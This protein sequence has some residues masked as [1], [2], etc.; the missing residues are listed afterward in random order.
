[1]RETRAIL[2]RILYLGFLQDG[3]VGGGVFPEGEEVLVTAAS[4]LGFLKENNVRIV[5]TAQN[6]EA[7]SVRRQVE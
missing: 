6:T 3:E 2:L 5:V 4:R 1:M 7:L